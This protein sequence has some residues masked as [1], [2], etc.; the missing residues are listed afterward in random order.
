MDAG[1]IGI[2]VPLIKSAEEAKK[3]IKYSLY[4]PIGERGVNSLARAQG[5][6]FEFKKYI[7]TVYILLFRKK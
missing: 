3:A 2:V 6:G 4:P 7:E 1:A 5:Y